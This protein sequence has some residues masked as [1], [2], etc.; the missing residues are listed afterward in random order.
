MCDLGGEALVVHEEE[1][2]LPDVADKELLETVGEEVAG[3]CRIC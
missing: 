2:E 1:V 3:L